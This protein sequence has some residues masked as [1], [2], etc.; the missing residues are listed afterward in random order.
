MRLEMEGQVADSFNQMVENQR[1][2]VGQIAET[3][4]VPVG[5]VKRRLFDAME[6]LRRHLGKT[7]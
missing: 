6:K 1:V 4:Q 2:I 7:P 5:T 3:L